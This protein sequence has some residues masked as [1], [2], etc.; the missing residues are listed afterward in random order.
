MVI[1]VTMKPFRLLTACLLCAI[2]SLLIGSSWTTIATVGVALL[3]IGKAEG[4][5]DALTAGAIISGAYFGD[6]ISPLSDTTV[7]AS[8]INKVDLFAHIR[9]MLLSTIPSMTITLVIFTVIGLCHPVADQGRMLEYAEVLRA[10]FRITPWLLV[11][12]VLTGV[13]IWRK[14]CIQDEGDAGRFRFHHA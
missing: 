11:V 7:L 3:G 10:H 13:M 12:P 5:A 6:K 14:M 4:F 8:S 2:V 1:F 9:Y